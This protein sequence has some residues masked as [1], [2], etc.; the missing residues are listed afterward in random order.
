[1]RVRVCKANSFC[2]E[3]IFL[4]L[5]A[6]LLW[7]AREGFALGVGTQSRLGLGRAAPQI[8]SKTQNGLSFR[9]ESRAH[10]QT[11]NPTQKVRSVKKS[12]K[13]W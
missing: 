13:A 9:A 8:D 11:N 5:G 10:S 7:A 3:R 12:R 6:D 2:V 1:M 4:R